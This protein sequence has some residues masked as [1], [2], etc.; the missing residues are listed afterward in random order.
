MKKYLFL[1]LL[2]LQSQNLYADLITLFKDDDGKTNWQYVA[3]WSS[4]ILIILLSIAAINL[5]VIW[6]RVQ[7]SNRALQAI[8]NN[9]EQR[10]LERTAT[11][12]ESNRL[13]KESN[14]LLE[15]EVQQHVITSG[16]LKS[17]ESY[18]RNILRSM[19]LMLIGLN[20]RG[21]ITQ[22]NSKAEEIS[23]I[24]AG[25]ALDKNLWDLYPSITVSPRQISQAMDNNETISFK[26]SQPGTYHFD[27]T[28]YPLQDHSESGV[29]ILVDD[30]TKR[31]LAENMLI[32]HDKMSSMGELASTMAHDINKPLQ[33]ILFDLSSFQSLLSQGNGAGTESDRG[34]ELDKFSSLLA[35]ASEKGQHVESIINNLLSFARGR[36]EVS[37]LAHLPDI[38]DHTLE[39][40]NDVLS[41]PSQLR[42]RDIRIDRQYEADLPMVSCYVTELQQVFLSLFRHACNALGQVEAADH[43]PCIRIELSTEYES[44]WIRIHHNGVALSGDEQMHLFE[45]YFSDQ[46]A[47]QAFDAGKRL[48]FSYFVITEQHQGHMAVTSDAESGTSFHIEL[49]LAQRR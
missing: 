34:R 43:E 5:F 22:W 46:A 3:N 13:L 24:A 2:F 4:G 20:R 6:R 44:L 17:S 8:R 45:P 14:Q 32:H 10:V 35:D 42:F 41:A 40:A 38:M 33:A 1:T 9:L 25:D 30:V 18:I 26:Q 28:V 11:L 47:D 21:Q 29:V 16:L 39:L 19:P 15:Q 37:Q 27:I 23:G 48:S 7:K 36:T 12:D 49:D 31:V